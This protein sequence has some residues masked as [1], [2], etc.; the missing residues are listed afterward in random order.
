MSLETKIW[1][2]ERNRLLCEGLRISLFF[3]LAKSLSS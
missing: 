1:T 3:N 2:G